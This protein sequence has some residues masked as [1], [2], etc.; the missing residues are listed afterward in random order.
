M[1][2]RIRKGGKIVFTIPL[3]A[4]IGLRILLAECDGQDIPRPKLKNIFR[5][6]KSAKKLWGNLTILE[7]RSSDGYVVTVTL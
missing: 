2:L 1:K 5:C 6:L 3:P 7:V 4:R